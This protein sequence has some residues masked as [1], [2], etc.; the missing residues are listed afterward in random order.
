MMTMGLPWRSRRNVPPGRPDWECE[1]RLKIEA[2]V[3]A[4]YP[5]AWRSYLC[6]CGHDIDCH[7]PAG[8]S[9]GNCDCKT[10][11]LDLAY[12][13]GRADE[14]TYQCEKDMRDAATGRW[15]TDGE[16]AE[17]NRQKREASQL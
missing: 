3:G 11:V 10:S 9:H 1:F 16:L 8:C 6:K 13:A 12:E 4:K 17:R 14:C 5:P 15:L 2:P 7:W